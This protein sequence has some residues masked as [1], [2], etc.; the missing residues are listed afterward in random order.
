MVTGYSACL[1]DGLLWPRGLPQGFPDLGSGVFE[2][3]PVRQLSSGNFE[4]TELAAHITRLQQGCLVLGLKAPAAEEVQRQVDTLTEKYATGGTFPARLRLLVYSDAFYVHLSPF[5]P[6]FEVASG[7][8]AISFN[9]ERKLPEIK[10]CYAS[11]SL[12]ARKAALNA[13]VQEALLVDSDGI[14][15]EGAWSNFFWI[16][17]NQLITPKTNVLP[18][19]TRSAVIRVTNWLEVVKEDFPVAHVLERAEE[20]FITNSLYGVVPLV[21]IDHKIIGG[22]RPGQET[23]KIKAALESEWGW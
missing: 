3:L 1:K 21:A 13:G 7:I 5:R 23:L 20:A 16:D 6:E 18:G 22:G 4:A 2:T 8:S 14:L 10:S 9:A 17:D 11:A 15:R 12:K 19:V